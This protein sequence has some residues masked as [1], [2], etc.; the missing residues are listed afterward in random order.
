M[1]K[2]VPLLTE[3]KFES[4]Q[5]SFLNVNFRKPKFVRRAQKNVF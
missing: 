1:K 2:V 4:L 5:D 3:K